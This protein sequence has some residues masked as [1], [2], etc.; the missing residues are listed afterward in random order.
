MVLYNSLHIYLLMSFDNHKIEVG[1]PTT[2]LVADS[3]GYD[4]TQGLD[5][6]LK[7]YI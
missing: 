1:S 6:P 3:I 4:A 7:P 2:T 5:G